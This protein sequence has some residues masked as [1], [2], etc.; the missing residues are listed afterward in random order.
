MQE[1]GTDEGA[2]GTGDQREGAG[3]QPGDRHDDAKRQG[4][5]PRAAQHGEPDASDEK[6]SKNGPCRVQDTHDN[7]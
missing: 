7:P 6:N 4:C 5:T 3:E 1:G 2:G